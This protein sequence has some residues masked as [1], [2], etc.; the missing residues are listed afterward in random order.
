[1]MPET[2]SACESKEGTPGG[3]TLMT[4]DGG[5]WSPPSALLPQSN[6]MFPRSLKRRGPGRPKTR[7]DN[8]LI[9]KNQIQQQLTK[10]TNTCA[11]NDIL[12]ETPQGTKC[13]NT[14]PS[15]QMR[16][17]MLN[18]MKTGICLPEMRHIFSIQSFNSGSS[19]TNN[20]LATNRKNTGRYLAEQIKARMTTCIEAYCNGGPEA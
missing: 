3:A 17:A 4:M 8:Y 9:Y 13:L 14:L 7:P 15:T 12:S 10:D 19:N 18:F 2:P 6:N 5:K 20:G 1:M 16:V 11:A